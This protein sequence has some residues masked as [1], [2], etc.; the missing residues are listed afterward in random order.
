MEFDDNLLINKLRDNLPEGIRNKYDDDELFNIIDIIWDYYEA[1]G[2]LDINMDDDDDDDLDLND[3]INHI[4]KLLAKD[5][6]S[7]VDF[8]DIA[9]L[10]EAELNA[11]DSLYSEDNEN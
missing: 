1:K 6:G 7:K 11:E 10:V 9:K 3:L 2:L 8:D 4:K 5:K